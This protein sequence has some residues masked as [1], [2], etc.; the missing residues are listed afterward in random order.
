MT[1]KGDTGQLGLG[2]SVKMCHG[3][4]LLPVSTGIKYIAAGIAHNGMYK[5]S[6]NC[7]FYYYITIT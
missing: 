6:H 1:G 3:P 2:R 4:T 7:T 5:A